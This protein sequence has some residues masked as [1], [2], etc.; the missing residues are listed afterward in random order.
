MNDKVR[1][2]RTNKNNRKVVVIYSTEKRFFEISD[3]L[4]TSGY[5]I[6]VYSVSSRIDENTS[7]N[8][9]EVILN[10]LLKKKTIKPL[11][12]ILLNDDKCLSVE[13]LDEK[14]LEISEAVATN[15]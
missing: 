6:S 12:D 8:K 9:T 13:I 4:L 10:V 15:K 7:K 5:H 14:N 11:I 1:D 3:I 2:L